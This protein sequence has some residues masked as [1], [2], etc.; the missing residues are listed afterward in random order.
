VRLAG[1]APSKTPGK[2][3][4]S[5]RTAQ[6]LFISDLIETPEADLATKGVQW[7]RADEHL[8]R[9]EVRGIGST[10][11][12]AMS[13][14]MRSATNGNGNGH[15]ARS[16]ATNSTGVVITHSTTPLPAGVHLPLYM[17]NHATT[18]LDRA[19]WKP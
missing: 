7:P 12:Y 18:P 5:I 3:N 13:L 2:V 17:D 14:R 19:C 16:P 10:E 11:E 8:N 4:D 1:I 6:Q 15:N 9:G